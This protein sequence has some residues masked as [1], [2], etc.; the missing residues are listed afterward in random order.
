MKY[1]MT[2]NRAMNRYPP[3]RWSASNRELT[4]A[5]LTRDHASS[6]SQ[7]LTPPRRTKARPS[8]RLVEVVSTNLQDWFEGCFIP[9]AACRRATDL[10]FDRHRHGVEGVAVSRPS[11]RDRKVIC[12]QIICGN[13]D[14]EK[15]RIGLVEF[16]QHK[17]AVS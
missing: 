17:I 2:Q 4:W 10:L 11:E 5:A 13:R 15:T 1:A 3:I 14:S 8:A 9:R 6:A 12:C 16:H 7:T